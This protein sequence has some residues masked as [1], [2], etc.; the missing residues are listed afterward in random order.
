MMATPV[1]VGAGKANTANALGDFWPSGF[2]AVAVQR[3]PL[4]SVA[5]NET[6]AELPNGEPTARS[7]IGRGDAGWIGQHRP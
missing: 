5:L 6:D 7:D 1:S 4:S 2:D 3:P